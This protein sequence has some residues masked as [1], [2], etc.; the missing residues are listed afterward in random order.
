MQGAERGRDANGS[1]HRAPPTLHLPLGPLWADGAETWL[2]SF[3]TPSAHL[4][5]DCIHPLLT[6]PSHPRCLLST[7]YVLDIGLGREAGVS[8]VQSPLP[9]GEAGAW[10]AVTSQCDALLSWPTATS[11]SEE[12]LPEIHVML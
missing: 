10:A 1:E 8:V 12:G 2:T 3:A 9:S 6:H 5:R 4:T 7:C 11:A